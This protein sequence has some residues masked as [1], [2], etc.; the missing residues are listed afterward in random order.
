VGKGVAQKPLAPARVYVLVSGKPEG[1]SE[2]VIGTAPI[3]KFEAS[4]LLD[5]GVTHSFVSMVFL[6]LS[7]FVVRTLE[8]GLAV[9]TIVRKT[10]VCKRLVCKCPANICGRVLPTNLIV[11]L[12]FSYNIIFRMDW[13][14]RHSVIIDCA[15]KQVTLMPWG[16]GKVTY[17]G[18]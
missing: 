16:E 4:A 15:W 5:S 18:S 6:R 10:V 8:L 7:R 17:V 3:L 2:V 1:G 12:M 14:T 9:T 11:L 13:L